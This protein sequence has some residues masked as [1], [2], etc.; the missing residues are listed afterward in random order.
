MYSAS[1]ACRSR[2]TGTKPGLSRPTG[3]TCTGDST[4]LSAY[5]SSSPSNSTSPI[6]SEPKLISTCAC[7][8][9]SIAFPLSSYSSIRW[10]AAS[11][12]SS[13]AVSSKRLHA[14]PYAGAH[15]SPPSNAGKAL[16]KASVRLLVC[17]KTSR[18]RRLT[19]AKNQ[20]RTTSRAMQ[21]RGSALKA[22]TSSTSRSGN[23]GITGGGGR[24]G[25]GITGGGGRGGRGGR[26]GGGEGV[27]G[28]GD[29]DGGG[30]EGLSGGR[31]G[32]AALRSKSMRRDAF[33]DGDG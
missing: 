27:G 33:R 24:G 26:G 13:P 5:S 19:W 25:G 22:S 23:G 7:S 16:D 32:A 14:W 15:S 30:A 21:N 6:G 20:Q 10:R 8:V 29:G 18:L 1:A 28:G 31:D 9:D 2:W 3:D 12:T 4:A 11:R 17:S